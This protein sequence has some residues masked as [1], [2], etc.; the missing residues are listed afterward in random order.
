MTRQMHGWIGDDPSK[1]DDRPTQVYLFVFP[2]GLIYF[3]ST[4]NTSI[5]WSNRGDAYQSQLVGKEIEKGTW[6]YMFRRVVATTYSREEGYLIEQ[7]LIEYYQSKKEGVGLNSNNAVADFYSKV[8]NP[9]GHPLTREGKAKILEEFLAKFKLLNLDLSPPTPEDIK[10]VEEEQAK[11]ERE[12]M[13]REEARWMIRNYTEA[14]CNFKPLYKEE[15]FKKIYNE[16][17]EK[18]NTAK[19]A[20]EKENKKKARAVYKNNMA[21]T[22]RANQEY[23]AYMK[24]RHRYD[25]FGS[26]RYYRP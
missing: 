10:K 7:A 9:N 11:E 12:K 22:N 26:T 4:K 15:D 8:P 6:D 16:E 14:L 13:L 3:G 21:A 24:E 23:D 20:R 25:D 19:L 1:M 5:R 18:W 17:F 2:S